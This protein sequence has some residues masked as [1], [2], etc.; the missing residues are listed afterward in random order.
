MLPEMVAE[1]EAAHAAA[2]LLVDGNMD[3][4][5]AVNSP[6]SKDALRLAQTDS[7]RRRDLLSNAL[8]ANKSLLADG[9]PNIPH[10]EVPAEVV[11]EI[12]QNI[13][14]MQ[15]ALGNMN[16]AALAERAELSFGEIANK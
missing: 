8:A 9:Y 11:E 13:R 14:N 2:S 5:G 3:L 16:T 6:S 7:E 15:I 1:L 10:Y 4:I 12:A